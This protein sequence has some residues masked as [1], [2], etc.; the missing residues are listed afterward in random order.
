MKRKFYK[1]LLIIKVIVQSI[2]Y[3]KKVY[4]FGTPFYG[5]IGD[6]AI[7]LAEKKFLQDNFEGF[8]VVEVE[9]SIVNKLKNILPKFCKSNLIFIQRWRIFRLI[10]ENW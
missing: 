10:M 6:H 8:K 3:R 9:I 2:F 5:N 7:L 1:I 4:L